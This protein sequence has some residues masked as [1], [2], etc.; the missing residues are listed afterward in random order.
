MSVHAESAAAV[1]AA[2]AA[3]DELLDRAGPALDARCAALAEAYADADRALRCYEGLAASGVLRR[4]TR[5]DR[6]DEEIV[7]RR[8]LVTRTMSAQVTAWFA[9]Q[10]ALAEARTQAM[11]LIEAACAANAAISRVPLEDE[12]LVRI[13]LI[14]QGFAPT[15]L[16]VRLQR[17]DGLVK[18]QIAGADQDTQPIEAD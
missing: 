15:A 9:L 4:R 11:R 18:S 13:D 12:R 5:A 2:L 6:V 7:D 8:I 16:R 1:S 14:A 10:A 3:A 17:A